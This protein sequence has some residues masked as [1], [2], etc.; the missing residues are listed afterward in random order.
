[1]KTRSGI[2]IFLTTEETEKS[3]DDALTRWATRK[4]LADKL[5]EPVYAMAE[6]KKLKRI[7]IPIN[8]DGLILVSMDPTGFHEVLL[9]EII[10]IKEKLQWNL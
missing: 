10:D 8:D 5:G 2:D 7:T 1:M 3:I 6:Y 4:K 9:K